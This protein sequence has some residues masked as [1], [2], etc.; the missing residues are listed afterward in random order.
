[1]KMQKM[2]LVGSLAL[3]LIGCATN[4]SP[5]MENTSGFLSDYALLKPVPSPKNTQ[6]YSYTAPGVNRADYHAVIVAPVILY[7]TATAH[8]VTNQQIASAQAKLNTGIQSIVSQYTTVTQTPG[9]GVAQLNVAI[10]GAT[11]DAE[12]F[13]PWNIIPISAA[14]KLATMATDT[15]SKTPAL[16][17]EL[18]F[19]DSVT[20]KLLREDVTMINGE[21]FR[22]RAHTAEEFQDLANAWVKQA[23]QYAAQYRMQ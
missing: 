13:K 19:T 7:Q 14:I 17:V 23:L 2:L 20:G 1:M 10:T 8:G 16:V 11:V 18:K 21:S 6:I 12:G 15:D 5:E 9:P 22:D 4:S 3:G